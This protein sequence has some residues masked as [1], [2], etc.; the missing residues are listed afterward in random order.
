MA[1]SDGNKTEKPTPQRLKQAR[2]QGQFVSTRGLTGA[3][4]F[5][6][7]LVLITNML[8][9]WSS[10]LQQATITVFQAAMRA[11]LSEADWIN[12]L[13]TLAVNTLIPV[14]IGGGILVALILGVHLGIT[15]MGFSMGRLTP[16]FTNLNPMGRLARLPAQNLKSVI[17]A[18]LLL[19]I[20]A[21]AINSLFAQHAAALLRLPFQPL[22]LA[23]GQVSGMIS[24][25]LWKGAAIFILFGSVDFFRE[26]RRHSSTLRMSK[27][28]I[29]E[30]MKRNDGDPQIKARIRR[31]RRDL[32]RRQMMRDVPKAT[33][34]I[35]NP[36]HYAVAIRY[37]IDSMPCPVC[38]AKG[39]N[40][41]ALRI[42]QVA[43]QHEVPI[44]ENPPL[45]RALYSS[46]Q[47]GSVIP[48]EFYKAI[49]EILAYIYRMMGRKLPA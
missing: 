42:R 6:T 25:L 4:Q 10:K 20:M 14:T 16:K 5:A 44:I 33:A 37:E 7:A 30:E 11:E 36:T 18:V 47:V 41:L 46:I 32:L 2:Q 17:E 24:G 22:P 19:G 9:G 21:V 31:L 28:E 3:L 43:V 40:W 8:P 1:A 23:I 48:P 45:A 35:V 34:V 49:A 13:R 12:L 27:Q 39:K 38:V 29:K 15:G 26:Y